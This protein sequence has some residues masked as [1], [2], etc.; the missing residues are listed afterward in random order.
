[1]TSAESAAVATAAGVRVSAAPHQTLQ[2]LQHAL[3]DWLDAHGLKD[4]VTLCAAQ[5][6]SVAVGLNA[7]ALAQWAPG[8]DTLQLAQRLG[9]ESADDERALQRETV[10]AMLAAPI[11]MAFSSLDELQ[12]AVNVRVHIAQA[13]RRTALAFC[14]EAAERP[15]DYWHYDDEHGFLLKPSQCLIAALQAATQPDVTGRR[16][17]FSCYRATEYVILLGLA[18]ELAERNPPLLTALAEVS[19]RRAIRSALF[20]D[21]FLIE[22]GSMEQPLPPRYYVPGDRVWFRNPDER[23]ADIPGYEG[24]WVIYLGG[25]VFSNFWKRDQ[26]YSFDAKCVEIHHWRDGAQLNEQGELVMDESVVD[27]LT[28]ATLQDAARTAEVLARMQ[29]LRDPK[30]VYADG[31]CLDRTREYPRQLHAG[32][33]DIRLP[34]LD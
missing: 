9:L 32:T 30:G 19:R 3:R 22:Y 17:D 33:S 29:R 27:R 28:A 12:S 6:G 18:R 26:P 31:G 7:D 14:T 16:Y 11:Q 21:V 13:A 25:G 15:P 2:D 5:P 1:M 10:V 24:S 20:H 8:F 4:R 23:S 34:A